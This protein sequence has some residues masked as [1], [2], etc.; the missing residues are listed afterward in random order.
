MSN[1]LSHPRGFLDDLEYAAGVPVVLS[2]YGFKKAKLNGKTYL[3]AMTREE[4]IELA[5]RVR[6]GSREHAEAL[7]ENECYGGGDF[8]VCHP[9]GRCTGC[10]RVGDIG[11]FFCQ[12]VSHGS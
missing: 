7:V 6:G 3:I 11:A 9:F 10:V 2:R 5:I 8:D 12:C 1:K 4:A